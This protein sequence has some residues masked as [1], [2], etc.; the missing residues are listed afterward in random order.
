MA[1]ESM[2]DFMAMAKDYAKAEKEL[3]VQR[4]VYIGI[5]RKDKNGNRVRI[6]SY[7]L[8]REVYDRRRWVVRWRE[9]KLRCLYPKDDVLCYFS[10]YDKRLGNDNKLNGDLRIL[11]SAKAQ[12]TK[13]QRKIDEYVAWHK[14]NDMFFDERTDIQLIKMRE[15]LSLKRESIK[16]VEERMI[17]KIEQIK[18]IK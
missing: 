3:G 13:V 5:E 12:V 10:F 7:D 17:L 6:F 2:S 1:Q 15:K 16:A 11:I 8:P 14:T 18:R 4:W 9:A